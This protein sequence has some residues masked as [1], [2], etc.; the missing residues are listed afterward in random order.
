MEGKAKRTQG[1]G[2]TDSGEDLWGRA[3]GSVRTWNRR[4]AVGKASR[5]RA[6]SHVVRSVQAQEEH[7]RESRQRKPV[8]GDGSRERGGRDLR[9]R[10]S[11]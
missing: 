8:C 10:H 5:G 1:C 7:V 11:L 3:A 4:D 6:G 9:A 2:M